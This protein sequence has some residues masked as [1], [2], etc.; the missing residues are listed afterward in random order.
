MTKTNRVSLPKRPKYNLLIKVE[1]RTNLRIVAS[2]PIWTPQDTLS[3]RKVTA[4]QTQIP[5]GWFG[6]SLEYSITTQ[7]GTT[8]ANLHRFRSRAAH[9]VVERH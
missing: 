3:S 7:S 2:E 8:R 4:K 5:S 6:Y 1:Q 9:D